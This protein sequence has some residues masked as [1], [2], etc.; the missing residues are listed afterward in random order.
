MSEKK[1]SMEAKETFGDVSGR[2][3]ANSHSFH[4]NRQFAIRRVSA[5]QS[6]ARGPR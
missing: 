2:N 3:Y 4:R 6:S 1:K 5:V